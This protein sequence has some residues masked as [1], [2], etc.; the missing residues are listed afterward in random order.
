MVAG[1]SLGH[2]RLG[3]A[4]AARTV[5][6]SVARNRIRRIV[7]E[8]FRLRQL[9]L[10]AI[11]LV[12]SARNEAR[13]A[14]AAELRADLDQLLDRVISRCAQSSSRSSKPGVGS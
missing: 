7:R 6:N 5:G 12:V 1:N 4:I 2:P 3:L 8:S 10:P 13:S 14:S 9:A 11:D